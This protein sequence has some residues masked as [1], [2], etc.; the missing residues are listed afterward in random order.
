MMLVG[1]ALGRGEQVESSL[2][3]K[4]FRHLYRTGKI[5]DFDKVGAADDAAVGAA[6]GEIS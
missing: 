1:A 4:S 6:A 3:S 2:Y 5:A